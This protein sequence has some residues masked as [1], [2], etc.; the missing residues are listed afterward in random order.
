[1]ELHLLKDILPHCNINELTHIENSTKESHAEGTDDSWKRF[2]EQQF[3]VESANTV[4]NRMKQK[5]VVSKWRLLYEAK[6]KEREEAKNR[7]AKKLEQ[8][9]AES[10]A[11]ESSYTFIF[12]A[13]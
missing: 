2:Y 11:S 8:S 5:K 10:Q 7:M 9:Y 1:M 4:I 6:Q 12:C 13:C 3:G